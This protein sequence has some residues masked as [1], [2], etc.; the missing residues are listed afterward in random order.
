MCAS[1]KAIAKFI[2]GETVRVSG[3]AAVDTTVTVL[4]PVGAS[5]DI[6]VSSGSGFDAGLTENQEQTIIQA[7]NGQAERLGQHKWSLGQAGWK[8]TPSREITSGPNKGCKF[9]ASFTGTFSSTPGINSDLANATSKFS[10]A[11]NGTKLNPVKVIPRN[12]YDVGKQG[13]ITIKDKKAFDVA[14]NLQAGDTFKNTGH[15]IT[16]TALLAG[17]RRHES[18]DPDRSHKANCLK[19]LR[20]LDPG[21]FAEALVQLPDEN[22]DFKKTI[23]G[24]VTIVVDTAS[25]THQVVDEA[26][27]KS[28]QNLVF[29]AGKNIPDVNM[30]ANDQPIGPAWDPAANAQLV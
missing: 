11:Q 5:L 18:G 6:T 21:V 9:V 25:A 20:A 1:G 16:Q 13:A 19:A 30:D 24:R 17:T 22:L 3:D 2:V 14:F 27:S 4:D 12:L 26:K 10:L 8:F 23:D 7:I 28:S 15:C 29:V